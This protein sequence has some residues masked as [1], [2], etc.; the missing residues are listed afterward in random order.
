MGKA[1][2]WLL[3]ATRSVFSHFDEVVLFDSRPVVFEAPGA[4]YSVPGFRFSAGAPEEVKRPWLPDGYSPKT[5]APQ[6]LLAYMR[7][8]AA[9][10]YLG[11]GSGFWMNYVYDVRS[12]AASGLDGLLLA[13]SEDP[14]CG[15][16]GG[17]GA[18]RS[19]NGPLTASKRRGTGAGT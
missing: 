14:S 9:A 7:R 2:E 10:L 1:L 18:G 6:D 13:D 17:A 12:K 5:G 11:D 15:P 3:T 4:L 16:A 8:T 19:R